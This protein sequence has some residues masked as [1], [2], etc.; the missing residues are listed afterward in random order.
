MISNQRTRIC[1]WEQLLFL[2]RT[3]FNPLLPFYRQL[4]AQSALLSLLLPQFPMMNL[5]FAMVKELFNLAVAVVIKSPSTGRYSSLRIR[6]RVVRLFST[7]T[8][9]YRHSV[10]HC[11]FLF[12]RL[13]VGL[14]AMSTQPQFKWRSS[15]ARGHLLCGCQPKQ[16]QHLQ[17]WFKGHDRPN[18]RQPNVSHQLSPFCIIVLLI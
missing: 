17:R 18:P 6:C 8:S 7:A 9:I 4:P 16:P 10:Q 12:S 5:R 3:K 14:E 2:S 11:T 1:C 13:L 15:T